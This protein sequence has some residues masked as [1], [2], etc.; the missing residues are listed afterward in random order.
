MKIL[1]INYRYFISGGPER[2]LFNLSELLEA[3]GHTVIPFSIRY[4]KNK[5]SIHEKYFVSP[6]SSENEIYFREQRWNASALLKTVQRSFY[7]REVYDHLTELIKDTKPDVALVIH[8]LRKLSPSVLTA[9]AD[10]H[11][12]FAV[13]LSDY[14]MICPNAHL[15]RNEMVCELCVRGSQFHSVLNKCVQDSYTAS[16]VNYFSTQFHNAKHFF[17]LVPKFITPS[18]FL[19]SKMIEGGW[20]KDRLI[21]IPT[22]V[23]PEIVCDG[24]KK[25]NQIIYVG[26]LEKNKGVDIL[27]ES[28]QILNNYYKADV[29]EFMIAGDGTPQYIQQLK[30]FQNEHDLRN[31]HFIG[32]VSKEKVLELLKESLF[33]IVP[34]IWYDNMPNTILESYACGTPVIASDHGSFPEIVE[35][36]IT[37]LLLNQA[38]HRI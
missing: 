11:I 7:S 34:S 5:P 14:V 20:E 37:G 32:S 29:I 16:L 30:R 36:N 38:T 28:I 26:R 8:Y 35:N 4:S 1:I 2:Y 18:S 6:L 22:F 33:S 9:L 13:R 15:I 10:S 25:K 12:P 3:K 31:V 19:K 27:L 23:Y 24:I 17:N 21:H